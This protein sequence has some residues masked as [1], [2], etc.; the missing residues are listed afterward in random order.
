MKRMLINANQAEEVRVALVDGQKLYDLDLENAGREQKKASIFKARI[1]RVEPSLEAAFVEFGADRHGFLPLKEISRQYFQKK[2]SEGGR[3]NI[4]ELISEGQE[5]VV[6]VEKEERGNKGAALTTFISLAGRYMVLMPNNPRAGGI[7]RRIE[8][9]DRDQLREAMSKLEIPQGMGV[10]IRTAGIGRSSEELQWDLDYLLQLWEAISQA[11]AQ[12]KAP[13][14]LYQENSVILRAIRDNLRKDIGEVL[15]DGAEAYEEAKTFI[16]QVMPNYQ[17]KVKFYNDQIPLFSRYQIESQIE[18]AFQHTVKLPSG[19]SI[20]IDP[21]EALVSIDINSARATKGADIEETAL[22][23]NLE[24]A[25][26]VARQLRLRDVGG[27]I[28][29]DFIDMTS[30][31]NQRAV[32]NKMREALEADRARVQIGRISRFGLMEMSRQRLRPSLEE[33]TTV[34]CPRCNGQGRIRDTRS[35]A[36]TILRVMEEEC[37]KERSSVV[38]AMVPLDIASFLLN[39]KRQ[40]VAEIER[41]TRTHVVIVPNV[42]LETPHFEIQRLR[43]DHVDEEGNVPSYELTEALQAPEEVAPPAKSTAPAQAAA[44]QPIRPAAPRPPSPEPSANDGDKRPAEQKQARKGGK[45]ADEPA[46]KPAGLFSRIVKSLFSE[47]AA[48]EEAPNPARNRNRGKGG[49]G[50]GKRRE[51]GRRNENRQRDDRQKDDQQKKDGRRNERGEGRKQEDRNRGERGR[52]NRSERGERGDRSERGEKNG[53]GRGNGNRDR[54]DAGRRDRDNSGRRDG[55][56]RS[57]ERRDGG[58]RGERDNRRDSAATEAKDSRRKGRDDEARTDDSSQRDARPPRGAR[59]QDGDGAGSKPAPA[60]SA[61]EA[62]S[63][64]PTDEALAGSKRRPKRDRSALD[65]ESQGEKKPA[66]RR[67]EPAAASTAT[68]AT[69]AESKPAAPAESKAS[70]PSAAAAAPAV[71]AKVESDTGR[72]ANDPRNRGKATAAAAQP[73]EPA[74]SATATAEPAAKPAE[75]PAPAPQ[76]QAAESEPESPAEPAAEAP[77]AAKPAAPVKPPA[78]QSPAPEKKPEEAAADTD[79][80]NAKASEAPAAPEAESEPETRASNDPREVRRREREAQ[81]QKDGVIPK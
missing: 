37:L 29:I 39:E 76:P 25:E 22:N 21:T 32:E 77:A 40:D 74:A 19:G 55:E 81:L 62:A 33:L 72:A 75:A 65:Q 36:L 59:R 58:R 6:Q 52:G 56:N 26:E 14:L 45:P 73:V 13:K 71:E 69:A 27:L 78:A 30:V 48:V 38:R 43:D 42:N 7:S 67:A 18:S 1:T 61:E 63:R 11:D 9:E 46:E 24:A 50:D 44:V 16:D 54:A 23:T 12:E 8:G 53:R 35:L 2:P 60:V 79:A 70:E 66:P 47:E 10:I 15:I 41:R 64:K 4:A 34:I 20:V 68:A 57:E 5:M 31:K 51:G 80:A 17:D 28:V 3:L 49:G